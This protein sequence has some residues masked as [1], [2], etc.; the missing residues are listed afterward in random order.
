MLVNSYE[1]SNY[2]ITLNPTFFTL[3]PQQ[4]RSG[5]VQSDAEAFLDAVRES[6]TLPFSNVK[7]EYYADVWDFKQFMSDS[8]INPSQFR[9][10]FVNCP[11][12]FREDLRA[13]DLIMIIA[14]TLKTQTL[15]SHHL[16]LINFFKYLEE[17]GILYVKD[18]TLGSVK[19]YIGDLGKNTR[20]TSSICNL[21][22]GYL[23]FHNIYF[24]QN[25]ND[26]YFD[27]L[28]NYVNP[29]DLKIANENGKTPDIPK[30][31]FNRFLSACIHIMNDDEADK[32]YRAMACMMI[33]ETQTGIRPGELFDLRENCMRCQDDGFEH[34][35]YH[36]TYRTW[37]RRHGSP[38][39]DEVETLTN[40][41]AYIA[42]ERI[43]GL[44]KEERE[45]L[46]TK[47]LYCDN[48][49]PIPIYPNV[50]QNLLSKYMIYL[51]DHGYMKT[52]TK[53]P[54]TNPALPSVTAKIKHSDGAYVIKPTF[55][56]YRVH[57]CTQLYDAG[58]PREFIEV[59]MSHL[60]HDMDAYY[61]RNENIQSE[62]KEYQVTLLKK[63]AD[64][65]LKLL[66]QQS[67]QMTY[68]IKKFLASGK[69][70]VVDDLNTKLKDFEREYVV[71]I[72]AG[73]VCIKPNIF[74][75][76]PNDAST[77]KL[78]C[79]YGVCPNLFSFYFDAIIDY[80]KIQELK[81]GIQIN[82]E[83]G[84]KRQAEKHRNMIR[85]IVK[86]RF[87]PEMEELKNE[88]NKEGAESIISKHPDLTE[89]IINYDDIVNAMKQEVA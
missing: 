82:L 54:S 81:Q 40:Q 39:I 22:Y 28:R 31:W 18:I 34:K 70:N 46:D 64:G 47:Y 3:D 78:Y 35:V 11:V 59:H 21:L 74:N 85:A 17:N 29:V 51:H 13:Y 77:Q 50:A 49:G 42:Y 75:D 32:K 63:V 26:E 87:L 33:I 57:L 62:K 45:Q 68:K 27:F 30:E 15:Y 9:L 79:A 1:R 10:R 16:R 4:Q 84:Q 24:Q 67:S 25:F 83:K 65:D 80:K 55:T 76:C 72:K 58:Y 43:V 6:G 69:A 71:K 44:Y 23:N 56:Q 20:M 2:G 88:V 61:Y 89:L 73:G 36:L 8:N 60:T 38:M 66:G 86:Q 14:G 52:V 12:T 53:E 7:I 19:T 37:K 41:L 48:S 5:I